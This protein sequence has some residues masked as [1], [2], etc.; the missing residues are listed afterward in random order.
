MTSRPGAALDLGGAG[1]GPLGGV[2]VLDLTRVLAGPL[3]TRVLAGFGADVL[4]VDPKGFEEVGALVPES[5]AGKRRTRLDLRNGPCRAAFEGLLAGAHVLVH[6]YRSDALERLGFGAER[7]RAINPSLLE[8]SLDAYGFTGPWAARRGFDSLVQMS[9]GIAERGREATGGDRPYPLPAQALDHGTGYLMAAATCR[10][11]ARAVADGTATT[12]RLSLARVAKVLADLGETGDVRGPD[13]STEEVA[14]WTE[15]AP[16]AFG[17][18]WRIRC[19]VS[20][21][22]IEPRWSIEPGPLGVDAPVWP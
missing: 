18:L 14:R 15:S 6:G 10:A 17:T 12:T 5:S 7:R 19:P 20:V 13:V 8:V 3:C 21:E 22:G 11:L 1:R 16:S 9:A 4:R 2:R